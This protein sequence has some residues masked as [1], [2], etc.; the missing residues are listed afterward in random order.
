[1]TQKML[2]AADK[3]STVRLRTSAMHPRTQMVMFRRIGYVRYVRL[4]CPVVGGEVAQPL[5]TDTSG[6]VHILRK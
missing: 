2:D 5:N 1:M 4:G 6:V 3:V